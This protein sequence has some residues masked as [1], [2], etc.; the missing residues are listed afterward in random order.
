M[1]SENVGHVY[2]DLPHMLEMRRNKYGNDRIHDIRYT[3]TELWH[4]T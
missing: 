4:S 3:K 2:L 1:V